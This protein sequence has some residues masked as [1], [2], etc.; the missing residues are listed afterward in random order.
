MTI[1]TL[2]KFIVKNPISLMFRIYV[3][4]PKMQDSMRLNVI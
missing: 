3:I 4:N 1:H 2:I